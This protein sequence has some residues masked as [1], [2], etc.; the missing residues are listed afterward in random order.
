MKLRVLILISFYLLFTAVSWAKGKKAV[1]ISYDQIVKPGEDVYLMARLRKGA[2]SI[3]PEIS[4]ERIEFLVQGLR[5]FGISLTGVDGMAVKGIGPLSLGIHRFTVRVADS[6]YDAKESHGTIACWGQRRPIIIIDLGGTV[7]EKDTRLFFQKIDKD[8]KPIP[9]A[10][11]VLRKLSKSYSL[12]F[13]TQREEIHLDKTRAWLKEHRFPLSPV[14]SYKEGEEPDL[15]QEYMAEMIKEWKKKGWRLKIGIGD[16]SGDAEAY[17]ENGMKAI[18]IGDEAD[19]PEGAIRVK[20][21]KEIE[22]TL[23]LL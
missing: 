5:S 10:S 1:I 22:K 21:W 19:I 4:G 17:I 18:I 3:R 15:P 8:P 20:G 23:R 6:R 14:F 16:T 12:I 7:F 9:D 13:L 2:F 11:E